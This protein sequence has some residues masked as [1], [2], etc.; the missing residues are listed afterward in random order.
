[1]LT[2][3]VTDDALLKSIN[4][5]L[6]M[7]SRSEDPRLRLFAL[8]CAETL[9]VAHGGKLLG[10]CGHVNSALSLKTLQASLQ[11]RRYSLLNVPRMKMMT[12]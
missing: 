2:D 8:T 10:K 9:W 7:Y 4:L 1:M 3:C 5:D 11:K 6:L 12:W